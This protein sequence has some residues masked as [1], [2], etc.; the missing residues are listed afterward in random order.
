MRRLRPSLLEKAQLRRGSSPSALSRRCCS[1]CKAPGVP[2]L[3]RRCSKPHPPCLRRCFSSVAGAAAFSRR[4]SSVSDSPSLSLPPSLLSARA[5]SRSWRPAALRSTR[6]RFPSRELSLF[7]TTGCTQLHP[8][9]IWPYSVAVSPQSIMAS[10]GDEASPCCSKS[11]DPC[12]SSSS[13]VSPTLVVKFESAAEENALS[14]SS[15]SPTPSDF[16][17]FLC[18]YYLEQIYRRLLSFFF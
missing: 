14:S 17:Q 6:R 12:C 2:E 15:S 9:S 3:R 5:V 1:P 11:W 13:S 16:S 18:E 7:V 10:K 8:S 4:P